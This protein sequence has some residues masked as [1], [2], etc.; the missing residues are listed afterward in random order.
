V[1]TDDGVRWIGV[2]VVVVVIIAFVLFA[3]GGA[4]RGNP[5]PPTSTVIEQRA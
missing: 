1:G 2:V 3:R 4:E 5:E